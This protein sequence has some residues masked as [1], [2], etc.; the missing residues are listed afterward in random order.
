MATE[1]PSTARYVS[2]L[3]N[4]EILYTLKRALVLVEKWPIDYN[5][6]R[7]HSSLDYIPPAPQAVNPLATLAETTQK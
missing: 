2:D 3:L 7:P 1:K 4:E 6:I 5:T